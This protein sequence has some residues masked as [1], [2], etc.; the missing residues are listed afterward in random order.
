MAIRTRGRPY[1]IVLNWIPGKNSGKDT[2]SKSA[3]A[4]PC[5][6]N[7]L[8]V[9]RGGLKFHIPNECPTS[10]TCVRFDFCKAARVAERIWLAVLYKKPQLRW[11]SDRE[12]IL[13]SNVDHQ[14][15]CGSWWMNSIPGRMSRS[16]V[17]GRNLRPSAG[18]H[19]A[20]VSNMFGIGT[21][22]WSH[23]TGVCALVANN[24]SLQ[25]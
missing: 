23:F 3:S 5:N 20:E 16:K 22:E 13:T 7:N 6:N 15:Y 8:N 24:N 4:A 18:V 12:N 9:N 25:S 10:V 14:T 2:L 1:P 17:W 19:C 21:E 11:R